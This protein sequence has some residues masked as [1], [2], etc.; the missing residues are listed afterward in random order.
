MAKKDRMSSASLPNT[1]PKHTRKD[2]VGK[3]PQVEHRPA[4]KASHYRLS[5]AVRN[6]MVSRMKL[7]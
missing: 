6:E 7:R 4:P 5:E 3:F 2:L 1:G